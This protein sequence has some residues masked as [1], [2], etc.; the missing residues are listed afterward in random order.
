M[1]RTAKANSK[2]LT[3]LCQNLKLPFVKDAPQTHAN[4]F[5]GKLAQTKGWDR[6]RLQDKPAVSEARV[7]EAR[8]ADTQ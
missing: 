3:C 2:K 4:A 6:E 8:L 1:L 7:Q 5:Y